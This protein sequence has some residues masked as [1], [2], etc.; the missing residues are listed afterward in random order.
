[1]VIVEAKAYRENY[2]HL[3]IYKY[4]YIYIYI[5]DLSSD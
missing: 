3:N 2:P 4:I 1:M 5:Y